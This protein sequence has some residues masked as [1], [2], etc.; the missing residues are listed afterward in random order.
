[1]SP[2]PYDCKRSSA[3]YAEPCDDC[4]G[5][6]ARPRLPLDA[7]QA[8]YD[9][10]YAGWMERVNDPAD[11]F[12][13]VDL[14][15]MIVVFATARKLAHERPE[16]AEKLAERAPEAIER[17]GA[18]LGIFMGCAHLAEAVGADAEEVRRLAVEVMGA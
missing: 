2:G 9:A 6:C 8:V 4:P 11:R 17:A 13:F 5:G 16:L 1:M 10:W 14:N 3:R 12:L 18:D 15:D 7:D